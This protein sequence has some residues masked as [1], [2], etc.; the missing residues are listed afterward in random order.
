MCVGV[1]PMDK[2]LD[3]VASGRRQALHLASLLPTRFR[4]RD[5]GFHNELGREEGLVGL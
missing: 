4:D 5:D 1:A 2:P 3:D